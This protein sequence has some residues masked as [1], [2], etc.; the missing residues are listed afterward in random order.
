MSITEQGSGVPVILCHGFPGLGYSWRHQIPAIAAA[1]WH[2]VAPD[3]RGYGHSSRPTDVAAYDR[4]T[5]VADIE[6]LL[7]AL[8]ADRAIFAGHDFGAQLTW[9]LAR[10]IPDRVAGLIQVSV[11]LMPRAP[12]R[13]STIYTA[14]ARDHFLHFHYFQEPG[15][16]E[17]ELD[18]NAEEF[19]RRI[20]WALSDVD[21]YLTCWEHP[22]E[23]NGY[24]DVLPPAA[25]LPWP[26][27]STDEFDHYV[28][29]FRR[30]GFTGGLNWYRAAD[31]VWEQNESIGDAEIHTP[32]LFVVGDRDP[33]LGMMGRDPLGSM[34]QLVPGLQCIETVPG[35]GHFVQMQEPDQ[36]NAAMVSFLLDLRKEF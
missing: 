13:P 25:P 7:D 12:V 21:R 6:G 16:A 19:L 24:L 8:G 32:T 4:T 27:L 30:T 18:N 31:A 11:P 5:T 35:A 26:W 15:V 29:E 36:V 23:G 17:Q 1:G 10:W 20:F 33:V 2:A 3:M 14:M 9:D 28:T 34:K 22:S